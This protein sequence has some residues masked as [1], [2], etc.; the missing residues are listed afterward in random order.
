MSKIQKALQALQKAQAGAE[1][2]SNAPGPS[3]S[4]RQ[5]RTLIAHGVDLPEERT[6]AVRDNYTQ[7]FDG[8]AEV[9]PRTSIQLNLKQLQESG[10]VP[11]DEDEELIAQQFR[12]IKRPIL[13]SAFESELPTGENSNVIMIASAMPGAGKSFCAFNLAQSISLERDVGAVLVDADVL[14][15][16][17]SRSLGLQDEIGLIDYLVDPDISLA[18]ILVQ[19]DEK[20]IIVIPAGRRHPEATE[21]LASRRMQ[22][23]VTLLSKTYRSRAV[24]FDTPPLLITNE[25]QVLAEHTGQI[26]MIIEARVSS[27]ESVL[28]ALGLLDRSKP[29]NAILNKSRSASGGG[30][31]SDDYGYYPQTNRSARNAANS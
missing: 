13:Q 28:R 30:Y 4:I 3:E 11:R 17:I 27:Q 6:S 22:K 26:V 7:P 1:P 31:Q 29:I 9:L 24:I 23:L 18:D 15:P 2:K 16:G 5:P 20:D 19:T 10:L 14:K 12:R 21:L 25:A 8:S